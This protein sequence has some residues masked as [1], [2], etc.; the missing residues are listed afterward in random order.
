MAVVERIGTWNV[1]GLRDKEPEIV[2]FMNK[3]RITVMGLADCR[4]SGKGCKE[5]HSNYVL[6]WNGVE[7]RQRPKH[8]VAFILHPDTAKNLTDTADTLLNTV[9]KACGT[10]GQN[11]GQRKATVWWNDEVKEAVKEKKRLFRVWVKSQTH[12]D[13]VNYR[14]VGRNSK[15]VVKTAKDSSWTDYGRHLTEL[16]KQSPR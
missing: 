2:D 12:E 8:G 5:I 10:K 14:L 16:C 11:R 13:Y 7:Q 1:C 15:R 6:I 4:R 3:R 9:K